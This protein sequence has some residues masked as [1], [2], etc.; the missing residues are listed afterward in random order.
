MEASNDY[1][2]STWAA[3]EILQYV[4]AW[5]EQL[6]HH[7]KQFMIMYNLKTW[8]IKTWVLAFILKS[9]NQNTWLLLW[10]EPIC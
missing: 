2:N 7:H 4:H 3:E 5:R 8:R 1:E 6:F 9:Q 10:N